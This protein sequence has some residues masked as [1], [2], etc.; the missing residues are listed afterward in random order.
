MNKFRAKKGIGSEG[1]GG[2]EEIEIFVNIK[3]NEN[4]MKCW[5]SVKE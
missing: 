4:R 3:E 2:R 5:K 1:G